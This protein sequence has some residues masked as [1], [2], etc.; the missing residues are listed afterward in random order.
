MPYV[1]L[2]DACTRKKTIP[3]ASAATDSEEGREDMVTFTPATEVWTL[4]FDQF[5]NIFW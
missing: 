4:G 2:H 1:T 3:A 5:G